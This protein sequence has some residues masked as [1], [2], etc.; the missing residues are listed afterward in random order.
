[1][2]PGQ[3]SVIR[4]IVLSSL[5]CKKQGPG[6]VPCCPVNSSRLGLLALGDDPLH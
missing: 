2:A 3:E 6:C 1:M 4:A 5:R